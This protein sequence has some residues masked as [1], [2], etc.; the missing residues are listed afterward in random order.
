MYD[1]SNRDVWCVQTQSYFSVILKRGTM[2]GNIVV[3]VVDTVIMACHESTVSPEWN[4]LYTTC[5]ESQQSVYFICMGLF[6]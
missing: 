6:A 5:H 3:E 4:W 2:L 1:A